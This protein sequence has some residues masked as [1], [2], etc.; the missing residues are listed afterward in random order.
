MKT[1]RFTR[2][3]QDGSTFLLGTATQ[4]EQGWR[5]IPLV[6]GRHSSRKSHPTMEQCLPRW[7]GYPDRCD[8]EERT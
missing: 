6:S 2:R 7:L 1:V 5:F 4:N 3:L 8:S